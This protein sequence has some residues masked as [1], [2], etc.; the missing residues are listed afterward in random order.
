M[1]DHKILSDVTP[2][3]KI[4]LFRSNNG[5]AAGWLDFLLNASH[6]RWRKIT[7]TSENQ[8]FQSCSF[9]VTFSISHASKSGGSLNVVY[10]NNIVN[11]KAL[12][13]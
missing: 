5:V 1:L 7:H 3:T 8:N 6:E 9:C 13:T 2:Q 4:F 12:S 11:L 10:G